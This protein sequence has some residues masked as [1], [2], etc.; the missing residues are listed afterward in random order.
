M[1]AIRSTDSITPSRHSSRTCGAL[2]RSSSRTGAGWRWCWR[3]ASPA[4]RSRSICR[5]SR[6]TSSTA[7][8]SA[9]TPRRLVRIV[10]LFAADHARQ[11]RA[12]RGQRPALHARLGRHPVRH[13]AGDVPPPA[14]AV[15]ALLRA[16]AARRHHVAHQQRHRRD[17]ADRRRDRARLVRQRAVPRRHGRRC[18]SGSTA[19]LFLVSAA[20][21]PLGLWALVRYRGRLE[22]QVAVLRQRSA[23]IG[24]FLI[25]TLQGVRLVVT[26]ERAGA[27]GRSASATRTTRSCSALMSM[28]LLTYLSGGLPGL[29]LTAGTGAVF[30]YGG[31]RVI[32]GTLTLG[33]FVA[34]MAYQMRFLPPLQA[35][36]GLYANLATARVSLR[37]VSEI[38]DVPVEVE[39][40]A[41]P[42]AAA[43]GCAA[44]SRSRTSRCRSIAARRCSSGCRSPCAPGEVLAIVGAERQRQVDDRRS[45]AAPARS[46]Q[47][48]RPARRPRPPDAVGSRICAAHVALVDQEPC[49]LHASI[50]ENI[51]YARPDATDAEVADGGAAGGARRVHRRPAAEATTRS[52]AS[53]AR[54]CRSASGSGS[55]WRG[56]FS[57]IRRCWS[58]TSRRAALD[59]HVRA[60]DRR[61]LRE[62]D[63][64]PDDH[65]HHP[66]PRA[67]AQRRS[68]SSSS[69]ARGSSTTAPRRHGSPSSSRSAS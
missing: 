21:A 47:R 27:R 9:A 57:P 20:T 33:T 2:S 26:A 53:A 67:G 43:G 3:S 66:S 22:G 55:R 19:R 39:E 12:E 28:Q 6:A 49:I 35:L 48:R 63:A 69:T 14:A 51:R 16:H 42:V 61:G 62:R 29:I 58:S 45:A 13:A 68:R 31:L 7:R 60:P 38:L 36:M 8:C 24:S 11:L 50:A 10:G 64:R 17:P 65:R 46:R 41:A 52:S 18:W 4:R 34:F 15:A 56:R 37:R 44:T 54:R 25:E 23:D 59:P 40:P 5:C 1:M 30:L 32:D